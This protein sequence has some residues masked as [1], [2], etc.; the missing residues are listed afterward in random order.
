MQHDGN[1]FDAIFEN[2]SIVKRFVT[3][4]SDDR[5]EAWNCATHIVRLDRGIAEKLF[6]EL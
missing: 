2:L 3:R 4:L 1:N 5:Q 6:L